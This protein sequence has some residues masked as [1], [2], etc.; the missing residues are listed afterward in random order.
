[1]I[2]SAAPLSRADRLLLIRLGAVGDV[3][4]TLPALHLIRRTFPSLHVAWLVEDLS[5]ELLE[6]HPEIDEVIRFPR[7]ELRAAAARPAR[8]VALFR[9]VVRD[10]RARRFTV[11]ADFQGSLKSGLLA[12]LSGASRRIGLAPGHARELSFLFTNAWVR[13]A[14]TTMNRVARNLLLAE[15]LGA[16][17]DEVEIVLPERPEEGREAEA[18]LRELAPGPR[19]AIVLSPGTSRR[20]RRKRWPADHYARLAALLREGGEAACLVA[21]GPGEDETARRIVSASG[22][23][24]RMLPA[25]GLRLLAALLRRAALFVGADTG[26]MHLAWGVG[27]PVVALF[28]PTDPRLNGPLGQDHVVLRR[29]GHT[30]SIAPEEVLAAARRVLDRPGRP[31]AP[32]AATRLSRAALF[33]PAAGPAQ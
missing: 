22:G 28:G 8:I 4:R 6:G 32:G 1:M 27:C 13:P 25:T 5:R 30:A 7:R 23:A 12:R 11:A 15:A 3:L 2:D 26:P 31:A 9:D 17:G 10:L 16:G 21:W 18:I 14:S 29:G 24:A 20:Q 19:P 33:A